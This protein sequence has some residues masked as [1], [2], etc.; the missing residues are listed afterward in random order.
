MRSVILLTSSISINAS[1]TFNFSLWRYFAI[2]TFLFQLVR[3]AHI[4]NSVKYA[5]TEVVY[6][7][8][9]NL[10]LATDSFSRLL[11]ICLSR[12]ANPFYVKN[13]YRTSI[14]VVPIPFSCILIKQGLNH[15]NTLPV[16]NNPV[17]ATYFITVGSPSP[18]LII[19][20]L[21]YVRNPL[22]LQA[23]PKKYLTDGILTDQ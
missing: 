14:L 22:N 23:S 17:Q 3:V 4:Q 19:L 18:L 12:L 5:I 1:Q 7:M 20:I 13:M 15:S 8:F 9:S 21:I 16:K 6:C 10:S 11:N 2:S